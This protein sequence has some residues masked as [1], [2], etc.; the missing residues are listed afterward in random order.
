ESVHAYD[1]ANETRR[2]GKAILI[3]VSHSGATPTT[4][5]AAARAKRA[6]SRVLGICGLPDSPLEDIADDV[7]VI[8]STHDRSWA[9]TMSYTAQLSAFAALASEIRP[10]LPDLDGAIRGISRRVRTALSTDRKVRALARSV[11]RADRITFLGASWDEITALE[12]ALKIRETCG[13][14]A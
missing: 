3:A 12:A 8:G 9:N 1:V 7:L 10:G 13:L 4:N 6:G 2:Q 11:A 5:R 14:S